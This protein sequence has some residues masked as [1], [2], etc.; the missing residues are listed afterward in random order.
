VPGLPST[1]ARFFLLGAL[2]FAQGVPWGFVTVALVVRLTSAGIGA[3]AI[4]GLVAMAQLPWTFKPALAPFIDRLGERRRT[5]LAA[6]ALMALSLLG[7]LLIAPAP[8]SAA[9]L[10][11]VLIHNL[12]AATQDVA[13]DALALD[14]LSAEERGRANGVMS[15]GKWGGVVVG[16]PGLAWL[17][18]TAGWTT[19]LLAAVVLLL[20]PAA[21]V[22][23]LR[24]PERAPLT[25]ARLLPEAL[26]SFALPVTALAAVFA[27][28]I[29]SS[30]NFVYPVVMPL[31]TTRFALS[32]GQIS[33]LVF[34]GGALNVAGCLVGG[35]LADRLGRRRAV[36]GAAIALGLAHA[37]FAASAPLWPSLPVYVAYQ[38]L[39]GVSAGALFAATLAFFM[40]I[41]NPRVAATHFQVYMAL[42]VAR[43][44]CRRSSAARSARRCRRRRCS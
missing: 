15:A 23:T 44:T 5:I 25:A 9:F 43:G 34:L 24:E 29:G 33:A 27:L 10:A 32:A 8:T 28:V 21:L 11:L 40:D 39:A 41:T 42:L 37:G 38:V 22:R 31:L 13:T 16:G 20:L 4:G 18:S 3:A 35:A 30:Q 36:A 17:G 1:R 19:A 14:L 26:R 2:Y 7:L 6:E 12:F